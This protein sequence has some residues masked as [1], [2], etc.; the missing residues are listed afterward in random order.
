MYV[1]LTRR[2]SVVLAACLVVV[3]GSAVQGFQSAPSTTSK[4]DYQGTGVI[5]GLHP[6][7][8]AL[9]A[10]RPVVVLDHD[11][12]V[13]LMDEKMS[14]PFIAA[15]TALFKGLKPADRVEF[16]LKVTEEALLVI[17]LR[18]A[19]ASRRR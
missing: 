11:P 19:P 15:S 4:P 17:S 7:P 2:S 13:G 1:R 6:P 14:M 18:P 5:V 8:S 12:I 3:A 9:R 10:T 16:G